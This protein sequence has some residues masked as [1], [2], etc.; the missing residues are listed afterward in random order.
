V[1][2]RSFDAEE[3]LQRWETNGINA[4]DDDGLPFVNEVMEYLEVA[5]IIPYAMASSDDSS[6]LLVCFLSFI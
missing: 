5:H 1:I 2:S 6:N 3:A 4:R